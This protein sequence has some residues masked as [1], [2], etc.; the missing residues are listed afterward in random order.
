MARYHPPVILDN[1][2]LIF[3][4]FIV[5]LE[6]RKHFGKGRVLVFINDF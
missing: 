2:Q 3:K 1:C 4:K 5:E 6:R